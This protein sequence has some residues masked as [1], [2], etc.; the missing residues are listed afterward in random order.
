MQFAPILRISEPT[1][2]GVASFQD[3]V[4]VNYPTFRS[5]QQHELRFEANDAGHVVD[6]P[7][8]VS[9][10][11]FIFADVH[12]HWTVTLT[13]Q[14][15]A[16]QATGEGYSGRDDFIARFSDLL[17]ALSASYSAI[18]PARVGFRYVNLFEKDLF[19]NLDAYANSDMLGFGRKAFG[20]GFGSSFGQTEGRVGSS[21]VLVKTGFLKVGSVGEMFPA[22]L[23]ESA[24]LLDIDA[25]QQLSGDMST[26]QLRAIAVELTNLNCE[27]FRWSISE[28]FLKEYRCG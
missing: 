21:R 10:P 9:N 27:M 24:W 17:D 20:D 4:R 16:L 19:V 13:Q 1:G 12:K 6:Q 3:Q 2:Q 5:E 11:A 7:M 14:S 18:V 28:S 8:I 25:W 26:D 22:P 23:T 15:V